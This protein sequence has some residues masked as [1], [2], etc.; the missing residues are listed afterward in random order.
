MNWISTKERLP[1]EGKYVLGRHNMGTWIDDDDQENV[2]CVV[3]RLAKGISKKERELMKEGKLKAALYQG[4]KR[5][6]VYIGA[7]EHG[8]NHVPY[9]W[10]TFGPDSFFGQ[11]ITHWIP[12]TPLK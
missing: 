4:M 12:I 8:N 6:S 5:H 7:D 11:E 1:E 10:E 9:N 3:V 2:N